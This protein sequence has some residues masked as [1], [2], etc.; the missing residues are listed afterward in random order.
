MDDQYQD[1]Q[2]DEEEKIATDEEEEKNN[3]IDSSQEEEEE[4]YPEEEEEE[5]EVPEENTNEVNNENNMKQESDDSND[6]EEEPPKI[7]LFNGN[8][9]FS[10][11]EIDE[12]LIFSYHAFGQKP[13]TGTLD[14]A[15]SAVILDINTIIIASDIGLQ[16]ML[17]IPQTEKFYLIHI[18]NENG[19]IMRNIMIDPSN[20]NQFF[21][22][23]DNLENQNTEFYFNTYFKGTLCSKQIEIVP[24]VESYYVSASSIILKNQDE[25][26][27]VDRKTHAVKWSMKDSEFLDADVYCDESYFYV[28]INKEKDYSTVKIYTLQSH[29]LFEIIYPVAHVFISGSSILIQSGDYLVGPNIQPYFISSP[30]KFAI[31]HNQSICIWPELDTQDYY[32][33]SIKIEE[34][35]ALKACFLF[36]KKAICKYDDNTKT[37]SYYLFGRTRIFNFRVDKCHSL[38]LLDEYLVIS[39]SKGLEILSPADDKFSPLQFPQYQNITQ[40]KNDTDKNNVFFALNSKTHTVDMYVFENG[41]LTIRSIITEAT[42]FDLSDKFFVKQYQ[43]DLFLIP[44]FIHQAKGDIIRRIEPNQ[45][46]YITNDHLYIYDQNT[47]KLIDISFD[48][49]ETQVMEE[50]LNVYKSE[51]QIVIQNTKK[52]YMLPDTKLDKN[53]EGIAICGDKVAVWTVN[54]TY[55]TIIIP[56]KYKSDFIVSYF[57]ESISYLYNAEKSLLSIFTNKIELLTIVTPAFMIYQQNPIFIEDGTFYLFDYIEKIIV[58]IYHPIASEVICM[59]PDPEEND[60]F[61]VLTKQADLYIGS[62]INGNFEFRLILNEVS[63]FDVSSTYIMARHESFISIFSK[64]ILLLENSEVRVSITNSSDQFYINQ[65]TLCKYDPIKQEF[66]VLSYP[67][68]KALNRYQNVIDVWKSDILVIAQGGENNTTYLRVNNMVISY[69][70]KPLSVSYCKDTN[71][72]CIWKD[73]KENPWIYKLTKTSEPMNIYEIKESTKFAQ[74]ITNKF[75]TFVKSQNDLQIVMNQKITGLKESVVGLEEKAKIF[76]ELQYIKGIS[77]P[78]ISFLFEKGKY[79][80]AFT[81]LLLHHDL[82]TFMEFSNENEQN[83]NCTKLEHA[84]T[85]KSLHTSTILKIITKLIPL[86][87]QYPD[88]SKGLYYLHII[89]FNCLEEGWQVESFMKST[90][91]AILEELTGVF[92]KIKPKSDPVIFK[93]LQIIIHTLNSFIT[94]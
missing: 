15:N 7:Y 50:I 34:K 55:P 89:L 71:A 90:A 45:Q 64:D 30:I 74:S 85:N 91:P 53:V 13:I 17:S 40:L 42:S 12:E 77:L 4:E 58:P 38:I 61:Y 84:L 16:L 82:S 80:E 86:F 87:R 27:C 28:H 2:V 68:L 8:A 24:N 76:N 29:Q 93:N 59:K 6:W 36:N 19:K 75:E 41:N 52:E 66:L 56:K 33:D 37:C 5:E 9:I 73:Q 54:E 48:L 70:T 35:Q 31:M 67:G 65:D 69:F 94:K 78:C 10:I 46:F 21:S 25:L 43:H 23:C 63:S 11:I 3:E 47:Y 1:I 57:D 22:L 39:S 18:V 20:S 92:T 60:C 32:I 72:I 26:T 81:K 79:D 88:D 51:N 14:N 83:G 62:M 44:K 49:M